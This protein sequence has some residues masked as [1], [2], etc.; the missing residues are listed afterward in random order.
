MNILKQLRKEGYSVV[1]K[2]VEMGA[3]GFVA[4]TMY[5]FLGQ[6]RIKGRNRVRYMTPHRSNGK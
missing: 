6:I 5:Q 4:G 3:K 2:G 1:G